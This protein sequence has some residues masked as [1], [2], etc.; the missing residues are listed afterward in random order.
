MADEQ[1]PFLKYTAPGQ[2]AG[3]ANPFLKY[4]KGDADK[5]GDD[6]AMAAARKATAGDTLGN[7][8]YQGIT[9]G[10]GKDIDSA[11]A[12]GGTMIEN[13]G[14]KARGEP[15]PYTSKQAA[16][17]IKRA[18]K[19]ESEGFHKKHPA[20][21]EAANIGGA[22]MTPGVGELGGAMKALPGPLRAMILG[23]GL[24]GASAVGESDGPMSERIKSAPEGALLGAGTGGL[25]H[26]VMHP[27]GFI[28][29]TA[30]GA[31]EAATRIRDA[32]GAE[33]SEPTAKMLEK[34]GKQ[35]EKLLIDKIKKVDPE[36][37]TLTGNPT[38]A[39]GKGITAA[40]ALGRPFQTMLKATGRRSGK[41]ADALASQLEARKKEAPQRIIK[42]FS[43][44]VGVNPEEAQGN[45][46]KTGERLRAKAA[47]LYEAWHGHSDPIDS[48][49]L[50]KIRKT[51]SFK[52]AMGHAS[53]FI[54][55]E[56]G[57]PAQEGM[58]NRHELPDMKKNPETGKIEPVLHPETG[59][60]NMLPR[61]AAI[62]RAQIRG[63]EHPGI[64]EDS[65]RLPTAKAYDYV[66]RGFDQ[67]LEEF[68]DKT[69]KRLDLSSP[70]AQSLLKLRTALGD[71]L[72][73]T[74]QPWGGK[75]AAAY[76]A[77][78]DPIKLE[79]AFHSAK[80]LMS[81]NMRGSDFAKRLEKLTDAEHD[82]LKAGVV[83][84]IADLVSGAK[85]SKVNDFLT[86]TNVLKLQRLFGADEGNKLVG[87]LQMESD[88]AKSGARMAPG[89]G[90]DTSE[91]LLGDQEM[92]EGQVEMARAARSMALGHKSTALMHALSAPVLGSIRG[93][94]APLM[95]A[96]RDSI[97]SM[98][99]M[100]PSELANHLG[101]IASK[102]AA[103][104]NK[105]GL[106]RAIRDVAPHV[107]RAAERQGVLKYPGTN[108]AVSGRAGSSVAQDYSDED[109]SSAPGP[110]Y[111]QRVG[112][113]GKLMLVPVGK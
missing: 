103:E 21:A 101:E 17:A 71:A 13:L 70:R 104:K 29:G 10:F 65:Q 66:K 109:G 32:L 46:Q 56:F 1:N 23:G 16:S 25:L 64:K 28:K 83:K 11:M 4:A 2:G 30:H 20:G 110:G 57:N 14:H 88:L 75:A 111:E 86:D 38:E 99:R 77:G 26:G 8:V 107:K 39:A 76:K 74:A 51:P 3:K 33:G 52:D 12:R 60:P 54:E 34:G 27:G 112:P 58:S 5:G 82:S 19:E 42:D 59:K 44:I 45:L 67:M 96:G 36:L 49:D 98:L 24:G 55:D 87:R 92:K 69:T 47:P 50:K 91:T 78:G 105:P 84:H 90:S 7:E 95:E 48:E 41:T 40:E 9:L 81:N 100:S 15:E 62:D 73:D 53:R 31:I 72:T 61:Q 37:K 108:A 85:Q 113:D 97:G 43:D 68:R 79:N 22:L 106:G 18:E 94:Q 89:V 63:F 93:M 80:D 6:R 102:E 35:G